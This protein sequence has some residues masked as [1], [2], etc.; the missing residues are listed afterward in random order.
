LK[1]HPLS[2]I[3]RV[4]YGLALKLKWRAEKWLDQC[5]FTGEKLPLTFWG[6]EWTGVLGGI[7]IKKPLFFDNYKSGSLYRDFVSIRDIKETETQLDKIIAFDHLLSLMTLK[8]KPLS[9]YRFL[10]YQNLILTLWA[11][12][13]LSL[14][15]EPDP[16]SVDT[17]KRFHELLFPG[18]GK[19]KKIG[20]PMKESFLKWLAEKT[21][22]GDFEISQSLGDVFEKLF[23][24][25][26]M[27]YGQVASQD[28]DPRYIYL[29]LI[30]K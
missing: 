9:F 15:D 11:R 12:H 17:F 4:G 1:K 28:L 10:T 2:S 14:P 5:W 16:F 22:T 24:E 30:E 23:S 25:I 7:L 20:Q 29:F 18:K 21:K 13:C 19:A 6:E 26:E 27:E 8:L 3:F